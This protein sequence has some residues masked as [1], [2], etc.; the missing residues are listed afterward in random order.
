M[1]VE[2]LQPIFNQALKD[3]IEEMLEL[4]DIEI[5][6]DEIDEKRLN[7]I[8]EYSIKLKDLELPILQELLNNYIKRK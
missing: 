8:K 5:N 1:N 4:E 2:N 3:Y 7:V 6:I